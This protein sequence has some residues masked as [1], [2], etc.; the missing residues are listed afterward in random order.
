MAEE[1]GIY[2]YIWRPEEVGVT[3]AAELIVPLRTVL[4]KMKANPEHFKTFDSP[5][6]WGKYENFVPWIEEYLRACEE[7]P[8]AEIGVWR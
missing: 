6:G 7:N 5:N 3:K 4:E 2:K 8:D 1:A